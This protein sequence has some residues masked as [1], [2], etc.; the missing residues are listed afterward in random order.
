MSV[1]LFD[2]DHTLLDGDTN[3][4]WISYLVEQGL[5]PAAILDRQAR[6]M[7]LYSQ[8]L[9]DIDE[10]LQFHLRLLSARSVTDW[11]PVRAAFITEHMVPRISQAALAALEAHHQQGHRMALVTATHSFLADPVGQYL[12][13]DV[14]APVVEIHNDKIT[15]RIIGPASFREKKIAR[16]ESWLGASLADSAH[17][18]IF[19]YSDSANDL[20][21]LQAVSLP[22]VVNPDAILLD[23][24]RQNQ[25][26]VLS[27]R[28][29][30]EPESSIV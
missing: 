8:Q 7:Q 10:Y 23:V 2:L 1:A 19:F 18:A 13:L 16:V 21:L 25:W 14:I 4:L 22:H 6:F 9:L 17:Q 5:V 24:A 15:G 20:A 27:W 3:N 28:C 29:A 11:H 26:P 30:L 12:G